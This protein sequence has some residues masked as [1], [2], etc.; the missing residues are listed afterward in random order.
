MG[1]LGYCVLEIVWRG[2]S[3]WTMTVTGGIC[4]ML[5]Y[6]TNRLMQQYSIFKRGVVCAINITSVELAVGCLI[7]I[8]MEWD[9]WDYSDQPFSFLGQICP[10]FFLLWFLLAIPV[11]L[12]SEIMQKRLFGDAA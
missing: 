8:I 1:A 2:Y 4:F 3:H 12:L 7:N 11:I 10:G 9:V 5:I 6:F